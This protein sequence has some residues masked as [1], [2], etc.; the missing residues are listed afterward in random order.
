MRSAHWLLRPG[1][2]WRAAVCRALVALVALSAATRAEASKIILKDGR[3]LDGRLAPLA[4][5]VEDPKA[6]PRDGAPDPRLLLLCDDDLRRYYLPKAQV[7]EV[8]ESDEGEALER[9]V[10]PQRTPRAGRRIM[11]VDQVLRVDPFDEYGRRTFVMNTASGAT[12]I[13]QGITLITPHW[14]KVEGIYYIWDQR[15]ATSSIPTETLAE[16]LSRVIDPTNV[17]HRLKLARL[18]LQSER[19]RDAEQELEQIVA[20]FPDVEPRIEATLRS[21]RQLTARSVVLEIKLRRDAGQHDFAY[22]LLKKFP[23]EFPPDRISGEILQEVRELAAAYEAREAEG[24]RALELLNE[25]YQAVADGHLREQ[26]LPVREEIVAELNL[27]NLDRLASY[28]RLAGDES[29]LP[30]EKLALAVTGWLQGAA[31]ATPN[32]P[33]ALSSY[34]VRNHVRSYLAEP[35]RLER[36]AIL[37]RIRGEESGTP[38]TVARI[39]AHMRPPLPPPEPLDGVEGYYEITVAGT[40]EEPRVGYYVQLPPEYDPYRRYGVVVT[41]HGAGTTPQQQIDWW[42]G[43][44]REGGLRYGQG[45]RH[46]YIVIAPAWAKPGQR[47]YGYSAVEHAA[48][49]Y[50]LRDACQRFSIDTD[51]VFLSG[52]SMG[53]DAA[54][55]IGLAHPDLWAGVIPIVGVS[56]RYCAHYWE[57]ARQ[58]PLYLVVGELDGGKLLKN[59]RDLERAMV[60]GFNYTVA[61]YRGRGHEHFA[62]EILRLFDWMARYRRD[63]APRE[64]SCRTMRPWDNFFWWVE[65]EG[66][67]DRVTA[68]P[69]RWPPPR[70]TRPMIVEGRVTGRDQLRVKTGAART[71]VWLSPD[72]VDLG[73]DLQIVVNGARL[74]R[75]GGA[76]EADVE[77]LLEDV[78]ARGDRQHPFWARV[79][80]PEGRVN[81][82]A[83]R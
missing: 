55:D 64:F 24:R 82:T 65:V 78:V 62:D 73:G 71:I 30:D 40:D 57:N 36:S 45:A 29:L 60:R 79:E 34:R 9:F 67:P 46:G 3:A 11:N 25:H 75:S 1:G 58:L 41:L 50:S 53:G 31:A 23:E 33:L 68:D 8:R 80:M 6:L 83:G 17:E 20:D 32:L 59:A 26:L 44:L 81:L 18:Y 72:L 2:S 43:D 47:E 77:V 13:Y 69:S 28:V 49:L 63:F 76:V 15:I 54:W 19:Y 42:S 56:D 70:G 52:H 51:R 39:V 7:R 22:T 10:I 12:D 4:R 48:V 37:A 5:L 14:T 16:V 38:A 21:L 27:N 35:V 61:E 74:S 66:L